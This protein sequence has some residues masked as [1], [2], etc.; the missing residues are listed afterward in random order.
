MF[1]TDIELQ[2]FSEVS[3]FCFT[4]FKELFAL[5]DDTAIIELLLTEFN[6]SH[7]IKVDP[8][9]KHRFKLRFIVYRTSEIT[10][11]LTDITELFST[12]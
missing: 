6:I 3:N 5:F 10:Q 1:V 2:N 4:M 12:I 8:H 11:Q 9:F 7:I